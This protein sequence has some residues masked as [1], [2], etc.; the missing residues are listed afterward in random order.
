MVQA[1]RA[2][3]QGPRTR[4]T[5]SSIGQDSPPGADY[6]TTGLIISWLLSRSGVRILG[7][8]DCFDSSDGHKDR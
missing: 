3:P 4:E 5:R 6:G 8:G 1:D 7:K 2:S